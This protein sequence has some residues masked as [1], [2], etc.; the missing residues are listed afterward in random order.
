ME[1][2]VDVER[3]CEEFIP[4]GQARDNSGLDYLG[5]TRDG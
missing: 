5:A 2:T 1:V 3:L 4:P